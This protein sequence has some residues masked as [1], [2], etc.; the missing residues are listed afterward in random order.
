MELMEHLACRD[1]L[2]E[3]QDSLLQKIFALKK[4]VYICVH[5]NLSP[6]SKFVYLG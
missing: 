3:E 5:S 2:Q 6:D 1:E 4:Y